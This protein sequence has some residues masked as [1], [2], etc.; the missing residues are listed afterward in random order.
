MDYAGPSTG[1][2]FVSDDVSF[3]GDGY[4]DDSPRRIGDPVDTAATPYYTDKHYTFTYTPPTPTPPNP[5]PPPKPATDAVEWS[6]H[7]FKADSVYRVIVIPDM[8]VP[9][10]DPVSLAAVEKYMADETWDEYINLGDFL[11]LDCISSHNKGKPRLVEGKSIAADFAVGNE[12]LDR[13]EW[14]I[15]A[16][17]KDARF[18]LLEGN[19]EYRAERYIDEHPA[20]RGSMEVETGLRLR[21]R[22][23][24]WVRCYQKGE[25]YKLGKAYFHHGL[26]TSGNHAKAMADRFGV[27]IFYGH[28]HSVDSWSKVQWG[29]DQTIVGQSLGC[30]C[31][32]EQS[33]IKG[34]P[35]NWQQAVCIFFFLPDGHFT[36]Y[37]PRIFNHRFVAPNGK[38]YSAN[39]ET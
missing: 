31:E 3:S 4:P 13:H 34:N 18:V 12:I 5:T 27:N 22:G 21:E 20:M 35:T 23:F 24:K 6:T 29:K 7:P 2:S 32:Y 36:Y 10:H 14:I 25:V 26:I 11:D 39:R 8:Q 37:V 33:Y 1:E 38:T 19:H 17:N 9:Y 16:R 28:V 15:R 30:L